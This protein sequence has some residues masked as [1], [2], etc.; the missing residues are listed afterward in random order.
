VSTG[1]NYTVI[2]AD[3]LPTVKLSA[4]IKLEHV[5]PMLEE[6]R[7]F[8]LL[9]DEEDTPVSILSKH[10]QLQSLASDN[11]LKDQV[12]LLPELIIIDEEQ[13]DKPDIVANLIERLKQVK[14]H[15]ALVQNRNGGTTGLISLDSILKPIHK[16]DIAKAFEA[17]PGPIRTGSPPRY[18]C[19]KGH[20]KPASPDGT[21]PICDIC[22]P[23]EKMEQDN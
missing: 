15:G 1:R 7:G 5:K 22:R 20:V 4:D 6:E 23:P 12:E 17:L 11:P 3:E 16:K 10:S 18:K 19:S 14:V 9:T 21:V 2:P 8:V 13:L